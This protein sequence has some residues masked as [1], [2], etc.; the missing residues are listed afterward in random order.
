MNKNHCDFCNAEAPEW[1][2]VPKKQDNISWLMG[3]GKKD[4]CSKCVAK[5]KADISG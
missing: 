4:V 1:A 3:K 2:L 5:I